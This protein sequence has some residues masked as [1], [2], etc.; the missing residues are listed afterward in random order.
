MIDV[1]RCSMQRDRACLAYVAHVRCRFSHFELIFNKIS[2]VFVVRIAFAA[3]C[4]R[5]AKVSVQT[6]RFLILNSCSFRVLVAYEY[7]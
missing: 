7:K 5:L 6:K 2:F 3:D 4:G 1:M